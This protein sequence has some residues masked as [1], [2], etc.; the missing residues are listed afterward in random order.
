MTQLGLA[1]LQTG[2]KEEVYWQT[3]WVSF[4]GT[5]RAFPESPPPPTPHGVEYRLS[6]LTNF[7]AYLRD[8]KKDIE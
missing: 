5:G 8:F 7:Y 4:C 1:Y 6:V 2:L 3:L